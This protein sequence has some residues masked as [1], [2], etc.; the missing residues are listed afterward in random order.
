MQETWL[1][2]LE[3]LDRFRGE[4]SLKTWIF[5]ILVNRAK[6][7]GERERR[8]VPLSSI[9]PEGEEASVDPDRFQGPDRCWEGHWAVPPRPWQDP[10]RRLA[11]LEARKL[12]GEAIGRLPAREKAVVT[13]RD[14]EGLSSEEVCEL[15]ELSEGNQRVILH[16]GRS[17]VRREL[18][19]YVD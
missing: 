19:G 2:V 14:V 13:L 9:E 18:E 16:R 12:I 8:S 6:T 17:R 7:R 4:A 11:S 5:R 10:Q 1:G 3:G 15:L